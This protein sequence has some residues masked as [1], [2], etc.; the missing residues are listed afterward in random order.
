[1]AILSMNLI[2][3]MSKIIS[4]NSERLS[5]SLAPPRYWFSA[6]SFALNKR[7]SGSFTRALAQGRINI[8][9]GPS[10]SGKSFL[11]GNILKSA[12]DFGAFLIIL[13]SENALD[14]IY[15]SRI[16]LD[17]S[18]EKLLYV[19]VVTVDDLTMLLSEFIKNYKNDYK[20]DLENAPKICIAIDSLDM[21]LT[22]SEQEKFEKGKQTGD[23]G[24]KTKSVKHMLKTLC[25]NIANLNISIVATH[26]VYKNQDPTNGEGAWV[27]NNAIKYCATQIALV[28]SLKL[29]DKDASI[30]GVKMRI[31]AYKSRYAKKGTKAEIDVP[32]DQPLNPRSG[33]LELFEEYYPS[34]IKAN[35][36]WYSLLDE[37]GNVIEKFQKSTFE[38]DDTI[39]QKALKSEII[40]KDERIFSGYTDSIGDDNDEIN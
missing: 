19:K 1:M 25:V 27:V 14:E 9:A 37:D 26:Q 18:P 10:G 31:E 3:K 8:L 21:L 5:T 38:K 35:G 7:L 30:C 24:Q 16:G 40:Q 20:D 29:K 23:M 15:L 6:G 22:E 33:L 32:W 2:S 4:N 12:Q 28:T 13:D 11:L 39:F 36:A 17:L 34:V